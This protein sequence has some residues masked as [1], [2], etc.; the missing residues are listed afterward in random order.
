MPEDAAE[1]HEPELLKDLLSRDDVVAR[2]QDPA[3]GVTTLLGT[4]GRSAYM[5]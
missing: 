4:G 5:L 1:L 3:F 2:E